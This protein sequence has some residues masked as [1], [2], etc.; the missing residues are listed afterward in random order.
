MFDSF[1]VA[2]YSTIVLGMI[3]VKVLLLNFQWIPMRLCG[4]LIEAREMGWYWGMETTD[5]VI[6]GLFFSAHADILVFFWLEAI[7]S[8]YQWPSIRTIV[9][10]EW[11]NV[12]MDVK[13]F[14]KIIGFIFNMPHPSI[15]GLSFQT[16]HILSLEMRDCFISTGP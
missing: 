10:S 6:E 14:S 8:V 16:P 15:F 7:L 13:V 4:V 12:G 1:R 3:E 5:D 11:L 2:E 9:I